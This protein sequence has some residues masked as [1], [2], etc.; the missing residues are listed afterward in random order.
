MSNEIYSAHPRADMPEPSEVE[1]VA[2]HPA[3]K[4]FWDS[5]PADWKH[6]QKEWFALHAFHAGRCSVPADRA[7]ERAARM[8][9]LVSL[10]TTADSHVIAAAD[11]RVSE[12]ERRVA[13]LSETVEMFR[14]RIERNG[15]WDDG[16]FYH[17]GYSASELQEPLAR[18]R[19]A[20]ESR[21]IL[22]DAHKN[23]EA[24]P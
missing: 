16:C 14:S 3:F 21:P 24:T 7:A 18:A 6:Q 19:A 4:V 9:Y 11:C 5:Q 1:A 13:E 17:N 10:A 23:D 8:D 12:A 22:A 2:L 15:N 20:L